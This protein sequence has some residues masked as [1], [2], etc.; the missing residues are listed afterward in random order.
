M[1]T[2]SSAP[3][4]MHSALR[5]RFGISL[6]FFTNGAVFAGMVA[7]YPEIKHRLGMSDGAFG[8]TVV[9]F[10]IGA[11]SATILPSLFIRR[12][13]ARAT[14]L[15][16]TA[17]LALAMGVAGV[18]ANAG[19]TRLFM[20][21]LF[22][23]GVCDAIV[24]TAQN[25]HAMRVQEACGRSIIN[26]LHALWSVGSVAGG[27][28]G[29]LAATHGVPLAVRLPAMSAVCFGL[30]ALA[31]R[32]SRLPAAASRPPHA[33]ASGSAANGGGTARLISLLPI[34]I[35]G[36]AGMQVEIVG[37]DWSAN[38]LNDRVGWPSAE[39]GVVYVVTM[40][41]QVV[42][43]IAGDSMTD[44]RGRGRVAR[45][46]M[47]MAAAGLSIAAAFPYSWAV[48][49]GFALAGFGSATIVPAAFAVADAAPGFRDGAA[50]TVVGWIMRTGAVVTSPLIGTI[51]DA[52]GLRIG[53]LLPFA[54]GGAACFFF[55]RFDAAEGKQAAEEKRAAE[56]E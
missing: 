7:R 37:M 13:G 38:Y 12:L 46:G 45:A 29:A 17:A 6:F 34:A 30:A 4:P 48:I 31:T 18:A 42:G 35:V 22:L 56:G 33:E 44:R 55:S 32:L 20:V 14:S 9:A 16:W 10:S 21:A 5:A 40:V 19:Y 1:V 54:L 43:R 47:A 2:S 50:L 53:I 8:L 52:V 41:A 26:S 36:I 51:S 49:P 11:M 24:D 39:A 15:W 25:S 3:Q 28:V 23:G 27:A